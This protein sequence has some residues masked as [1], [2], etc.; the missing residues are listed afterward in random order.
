MVVLVENSVPLPLAS[1]FQRI[2]VQPSRVGFAGNEE[3]VFAGSVT[4]LVWDAVLP[5]QLPPFGLKVTVAAHC[6][7]TVIFPFTGVVA[8]NSVPLPLAAV[9]QPAKFQ[10]VLVG[11]VAGSEPTLPLIV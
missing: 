7:Y 5:L 6:A 11:T 4:V 3:T 2:N 9:F 8:K 1:V 10:P